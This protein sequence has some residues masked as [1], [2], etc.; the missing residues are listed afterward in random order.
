MESFVGLFRGFRWF[1]RGRLLVRAGFF[2]DFSF[3]VGIA[4][5]L[6]FVVG[7]IVWN[8]LDSAAISLAV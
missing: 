7:G 4:P 1:G 2:G 8:S 6:Q 3:P 5:S